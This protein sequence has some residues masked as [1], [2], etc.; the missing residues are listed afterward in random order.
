[1]NRRSAITLIVVVALLLATTLALRWALRPQFLGPRILASAGA[2]FGLEIRAEAFD[3]R[4]GREPWLVVRGLSAREP[5]SPAPM[6]EAGRL[7][8]AVPWST[9]RSRGSDPVVA[10]LEL[11]APRVQLEPLL[12]W[13]R[14][15]PTGDGSLPTLRR[16]LHVKRG[17]I[18]AGEWSLREIDVSVPTFAPDARFSGRVRGQWEAA[19]MEVPFDLRL[20]MTRPAPGTG[21]GVAGTVT[22]RAD[23]WRLPSR[24]S[25]SARIDTQA[26][27][28]ARLRNLR[29]A[30]S[31]RYVSGDAVQPFAL[32]VAGEA[33]VAGGTLSLA[34]AVL[35]L[36]GQGLVPDL[37]GQGRLDTGQRLALELA[38]EIERWPEA[39]PALPAPIGDSGSPMAFQLGYRGPA[40][41]AGPLALQLARDDARFEGLLHLPRLV[42][43]TSGPRDGSPLPPL[44]GQ[45]TVSRVEAAGATLHGVQVSIHDPADNGRQQ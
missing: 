41:L 36:R 42:A 7:L 20:A 26:G 4:L 2:A 44:E 13:W 40:N 39:W 14:R 32:G 45:M 24:V 23:G 27:P 35:A 10:R 28:G 38:G 16:G 43:W 3:Y 8:V 31:S 19:A 1:M 29:L 11:D 15:R 9:L 25:L 6:A 30:S 37:R 5:G 22:P 33:V 18:D 21:L 12:E 17:R 34:P